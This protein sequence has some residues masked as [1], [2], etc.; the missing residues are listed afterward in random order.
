MYHAIRFYPA[1]IYMIVS[2]GEGLF[3]CGDSDAAV[4]SLHKGLALAERAGM[5]F[6]SGYAHR[7]LGEM[8]L[9][10][11]T[12]QASTHFKQA[13]TAFKKTGAENELALAFIGFGQVQKKKGNKVQVRK[14]LSRA[15]EISNRLDAFIEQ[16]RVKEVMDELSQE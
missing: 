11:N 13:I 8:A 15:L 16:N 1:E 4:K 5:K 7:L 12:E 14:Y 3:R 6:L 9:E 2:I 10:V